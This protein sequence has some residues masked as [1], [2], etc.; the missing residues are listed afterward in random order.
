M[1][2]LAWQ[3]AAGEPIN[4]AANWRR[5]AIP[6]L[7]ILT[8]G[9]GMVAWAE[10]YVSSS[11]AAIMGATAPFW[12]IALDRKN[13]SAYFSD[14]LVLTGITGG[15]IGLLLFMNGSLL[16]APAGGPAVLRILGFLVLALSAVSWVLGAIYSKRRPAS[17]SSLLNTA[18]QLIA[19]GLGSL[20]IAFVRGE[21]A[22]AL[23][24]SVPGS[25]WAA[26]IFLVF[27]GSIIAYQSYTW[28]LRVQ[29][30]AIVSVHTYINP[31]VAVVIGWIFLNEVATGLQLTG[32]LI[33]LTGV[34]LTNV[35]RYKMG[36]RTKVRIRQRMRYA[37]L[38]LLEGRIARS[39][40]GLRN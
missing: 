37:G 19:G 13:R 12:F 7:L 8:G 39:V 3:S 38:L 25:A 9:T 27:F 17:G 18:Q 2:L 33:I 6:G 23:Q 4:I 30:P 31:V 21:P 10:Q 28:L 1:L 40:S 32:L 35:S 15:F 11:E 22:Q 5:N 20:A 14:R 16:H 29:P 34:F 36:L 24:R 26:L